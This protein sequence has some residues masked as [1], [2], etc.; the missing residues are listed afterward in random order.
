MDALT[1]RIGLAVALVVALV[2]LYLILRIYLIGRRSGTFRTLL[3]RRGQDGWRRGFAS[4]GATSVAWV[5]VISFRIRPQIRLRR[6]EMEIIGKPIV[7][8][9]T[10]TATLRLRS[11]STEYDLILSV[12]DYAGLISWIDSG[13]PG[14][15]HYP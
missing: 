11:E 10:S 2:A 7:S 6:G 14:Q 8:A 3:R 9:G 5:P 13:A 1:L 12:G 4:Y 15:R